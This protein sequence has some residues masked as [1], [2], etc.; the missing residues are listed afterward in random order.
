MRHD[1]SPFAVNT[2]SYIFSHGAG[3]CLAH[4][5]NQGYAEFELLLQP[6]HL[7][8]SEL[9]AGARRDLRRIIER[10]TR[11]VS[12]LNMPSLDFNLAAPAA[13]MR[14]Y[15]L[16]IA[17]ASLDLAG[18][19]GVPAVLIGPGK[20]SQL[21][22]LPA[23]RMMG[24]FFEA[25]DRLVPRAARAGTS[26]V[27][28]NLPMAFLPDAPSLAAALDRY[29]D[30]RVGIVY[31]LANAVFIGE[32][33]ADGLRRVRDRLRLIHLSDTTRAVFRHDPVGQGIVPFATIPPVLA[34]IGFA[35]TP[36]LEIISPEPDRD[37]AASAQALI[38]VGW[39]ATRRD[40]A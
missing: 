1:P 9:D 6:G 28:E 31:D 4:L 21:F 17:E 18:D 36:I 38:A 34:E 10:R 25:L 27:I 35:A 2:Y 26:V 15:S 24:Y 14:A 3:D 22:A 23:E 8:P 20:P 5:A 37:I 11:G 7:W 12:T 32:N 40:P 33:P 30:P 16:A 39:P 13:E 29:G 19:L